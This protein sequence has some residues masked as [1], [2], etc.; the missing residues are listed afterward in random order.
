MTGGWLLEIEAGCPTMKEINLE[1]LKTHFNKPHWE[2]WL[3]PL[4]LFKG[5]NPARVHASYNLAVAMFLADV[6]NTG[7]AVRLAA[8]DDVRH[9]C[10]LQ[11]NV[12]NSSL[13][14]IFS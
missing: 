7:D 6:R 3:K 8:R 10:G 14:S 1:K 2:Q 12:T 13:H 5:T 9:L 11:N 4:F